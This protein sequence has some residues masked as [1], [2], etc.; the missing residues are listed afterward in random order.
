M[1]GTFLKFW[2]HRE[3]EF[4]S[5]L[6]ANFPIFQ[7]SMYIRNA[8]VDTSHHNG[9]QNYSISIWLFCKKTLSGIIPIYCIMSIRCHSKI[10]RDMMNFQNRYMYWRRTKMSRTCLVQVFDLLRVL[11]DPKSIRI[12]FDAYL[13]D[14]LQ[15]LKFSKH[16]E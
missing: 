4:F 2:F 11:Y 7:F 5:K 1:A 12:Y 10:E 6:P 3:R 16:S 13:N 14:I 9:N 8:S 15:V